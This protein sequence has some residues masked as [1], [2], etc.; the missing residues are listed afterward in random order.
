[1][2]TKRVI[3][4]PE[5]DRIESKPVEMNVQVF[6]DRCP[7]ND[8]IRAFADTVGLAA[9]GISHDVSPAD[10]IPYAMFVLGTGRVFRAYLA[11]HAA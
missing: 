1:M 10:G 11:E 4:A 3:I 8:A 2:Q 9:F 6:L 5:T 7:L